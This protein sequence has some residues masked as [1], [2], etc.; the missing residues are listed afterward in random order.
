MATFETHIN[1]IEDAGIATLRSDLT[2]AKKIDLYTGELD[3]MPEHDLKRHLAQLK[4]QFPL[5]LFGY[6][7][8]RDTE[9]APVGKSFGESLV[10]R[11]DCSF[12]AFCCSTN[13]R[14]ARANKRGRA[15]ATGQAAEIGV[16][17]MISDVRESLTGLQFYKTVLDENGDPVLDANG[18][19]V[20]IAL[21]AP[22]KPTGNAY[23]A[24][25]PNIYVY[26]VVF[27]TWF[28][29][30]SRDRKPGG[31]DVDQIIVEV[32]LDIDADARQST[33]TPGVFLGGKAQHADD[34]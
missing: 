2:Y 4:A 3:G 34:E 21:C 10:F 12:I 18:K 28:R 29:W 11:H 31:I 9:D 15:A 30:R 26:A 7:D 16:V 19:P 20:E 25:L 14:G 33:N 22:F 27:D 6:T 5:I 23:V 24:K 1:E 13:V 32:D 17:K 8:G